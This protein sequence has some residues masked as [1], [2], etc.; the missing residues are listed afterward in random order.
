MKPRSKFLKVRCKDCGN[1]QIIFNKA[2]STIKCQACSAVL[3][4]PTGG[5]VRVKAEIVKEME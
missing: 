3:A 2:S 5:K 4:E 1:E